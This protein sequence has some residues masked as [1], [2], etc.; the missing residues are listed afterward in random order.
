VLVLGR[1]EVTAQLIG[2]G[3]QRLLESQIR[4]ITTAWLGHQAPITV[5]PIE[6]AA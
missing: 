2:G 3:P 6:R 5:K 4:A 1:V